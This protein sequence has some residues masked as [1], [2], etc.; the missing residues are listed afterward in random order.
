M[1]NTRPKKWWDLPANQQLPTM[2]ANSPRNKSPT[3]SASRPTPRRSVRRT[4]TVMNRV[5]FNFK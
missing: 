4:P 1:E 5:P 2:A 3:R